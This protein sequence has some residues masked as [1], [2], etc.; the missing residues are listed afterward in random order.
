MPHLRLASNQAVLLNEK[1]F[2][3]GSDPACD[4]AL[5][6]RDILPRHLILQPRGEQWQAATL[7]LRAAAFINDRPLTGI[8]LLHDGD[9][10]RV[11]SVTM[12]WHEQDLQG[13][14]SAP[15]AGLLS[16]LLIVLIMMSALFVWFNFSGLHRAPDATPAIIQKIEPQPHLQFQN[17][18]ENGHPLYEIVVPAP[19]D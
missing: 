12:T 5:K 19:V 3:I 14:M 18:S 2:V 6:Q 11:G 8:A 16:I 9:R 10:I 13:E 4:L 15:W 1:A 7:N 17:L